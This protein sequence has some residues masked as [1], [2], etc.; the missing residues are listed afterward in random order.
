MSVKFTLLITFSSLRECQ[1]PS[2][3]SLPEER[4]FDWLIQTDSA[5][6]LLQKAFLIFFM[7]NEPEG[8]L[9]SSMS[10]IE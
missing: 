5:D 8:L 2:V 9:L 6:L 3:L 4:F 7:P 1:K 10:I